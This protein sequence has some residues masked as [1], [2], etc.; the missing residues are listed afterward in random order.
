MQEE[1]LA[2]VRRTIKENYYVPEHRVTLASRAEDF[3]IDSLGEVE[4]AMSL[5]EEFDVL[6][7]DSDLEQVDTLGDL[8]ELVIQKRSEA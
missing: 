7:D 6:I 5:E 2:V 1:I 8:V 4:I 3:G